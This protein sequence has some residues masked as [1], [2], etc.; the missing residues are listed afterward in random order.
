[1]PPAPDQSCQPGPP[2]A[3]CRPAA[4]K[5]A[6]GP[7]KCR[8]A[9]GPHSTAGCSRIRRGA[10]APALLGPEAA[11]H[12]PGPSAV[13]RHVHR[14][15]HAG[16]AANGAPQM[17][18][19]QETRPG[20]V[21]AL[22]AGLQACAGRHQALGPGPQ[23]TSTSGELPV[24]LWRFR[25]NAA[26][27]GRAGNQA[28]PARPG[29]WRRAV[30]PHILLCAPAPSQPMQPV[31]KLAGSSRPPGASVAVPEHRAQAGCAS[32]PPQVL[33]TAAR[34]QARLGERMPATAEQ[35]P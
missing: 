26:P 8:T 10:F 16:G 22:R 2:E 14:L 17:S 33:L 27:R 23:R 30:S 15:G 28:R 1:M 32:R 31:L 34:C 25:S 29:R 18:A 4:G 21:P 35:W 12:W 7:A 9:Q 19:R 11:V 5:A 20:R 24:P 3:V 6:R 13:L